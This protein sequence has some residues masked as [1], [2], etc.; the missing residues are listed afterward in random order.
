MI[1]SYAMLLMFAVYIVCVD[2]RKIKICYANFLVRDAV[3]FQNIRFN[4]V[5]RQAHLIVMPDKT[6]D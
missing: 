2:C 5:R 6:S 1:V 3:L 4:V